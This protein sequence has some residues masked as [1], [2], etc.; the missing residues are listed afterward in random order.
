MPSWITEFINRLGAILS[1]PFGGIVGGALS[2]V[3]LELWVRKKR[4]QHQ[5]AESLAAELANAATDLK[6]HIDDPDPDEIPGYFRVSHV[7][8]DALASRIGELEFQDVVSVTKV[9]RVLD[10]LNRMPAAWRERASN[11]YS[12]PPN[13]PVRES[14]LP[15]L[16]EG[17][18]GFY[19]TLNTSYNDCRGLGTHLRTKYALGFRGLVPLR[20]RPNKGLDT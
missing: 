19:R 7:V 20:L 2:F 12:L 10:E 6:V 1:G 3:V 11:A 16:E 5:V 17:R 9:Y 4:Q 18:A 15:I 14:E 13:H 8:F